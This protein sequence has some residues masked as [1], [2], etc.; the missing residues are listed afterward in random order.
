MNAA[1]K[2]K[3][4]IADFWLQPSWFEKFPFYHSPFSEKLKAFIR[5]P[6]FGYIIFFI[7][8]IN[9]LAVIV[10]TTVRLEIR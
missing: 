7:L 8:I 9:M 4:D 3:F 10:E 2:L 5:S 6:K 1:F